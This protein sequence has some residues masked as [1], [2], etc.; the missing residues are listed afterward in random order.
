MAAFKKS[1][2]MIYRKAFVF[3]QKTKRRKPQLITKFTPF[4]KGNFDEHQY[5]PILKCNSKDV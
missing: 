3:F 4:L 5:L 2:I 1:F